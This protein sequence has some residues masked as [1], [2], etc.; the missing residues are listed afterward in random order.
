[1]R[2]EIIMAKV[3]VVY[4]SGSGNTE[5]MALAIQSAAKA[6]GADV[7]LYKAM[8]FSASMVNQFDSVVFGCPARGNE[9]LE[10]ETMQPLWDAC[11]TQLRG[12]RIGLF[13]SY[14]SGG[15]PWMQKWEED[16]E[17]AGAKLGSVSVI[18]KGKPDQNA[19]KECVILGVAL[20]R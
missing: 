2:E 1:M 7:H 3:A 13:G 20:A 15:G 12:K 18:C 19:L 10:E 16:A 11:K 5:Q 6:A 8:D 14:G 4:W 9:Q 17:K